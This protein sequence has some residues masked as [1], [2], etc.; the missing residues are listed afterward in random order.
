MVHLVAWFVPIPGWWLVWLPAGRLAAPWPTRFLHFAFS[1]GRKARHSKATSFVL[2][3]VQARTLQHPNLAIKRRHSSQFGVSQILSY[4]LWHY[5]V[6]IRAFPGTKFPPSMQ[7]LLASAG[8]IKTSPLVPDWI[9]LLR[10]STSSLSPLKDSRFGNISDKSLNLSQKICGRNCS[11]AWTRRRFQRFLVEHLA[12]R[13]FGT[14]ESAKSAD[15]LRWGGFRLEVCIQHVSSIFSGL[16]GLGSAP[17]SNFWLLF[18]AFQR[19]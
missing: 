9:C 8:W 13:H 14:L 18:C 11:E 3:D 7:L 12:E 5:I 10:T 1:K 15:A 6:H 19:C 16:Y 2:L 4:W 17:A